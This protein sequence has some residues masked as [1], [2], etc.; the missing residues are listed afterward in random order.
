MKHGVPE[1][2]AN[3]TMR[4]HRDIGDRC[5]L[6]EGENPV[7]KRPLGVTGTDSELTCDILMAEDAGEVASGGDARVRAGTERQEV[8]LVASQVMHLRRE[9]ADTRQEV[10]RCQQANKVVLA[11]M[12]R[13]LARLA[14]APA[15]RTVAADDDNEDGR[16]RLLPVP[17]PR[18]RSLHDLW[19]EWE[20]G[21]P[22]RKPAKDF[23]PNERGKAKNAFSHRKPLWDK[24]NEL[25]RSGMSAQVARDT[26][27][28]V[29]GHRMTV[30]KTLK[31]LA[32]DRR[33]GRWPDRLRIRVIWAHAQSHVSHLFFGGSAS[34]HTFF[35]G[36][37]TGLCHTNQQKPIH[38]CIVFCGT[39]FFRCSVTKR[40]PP[41]RLP[42][43]AERCD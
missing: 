43:C 16:P 35:C 31:R 23:A 21:G 17:M 28:D 20:F 25:T 36:T 33:T 29:H 3:R 13:N 41:P 5:T 30:T 1:E 22:G 10:A 8:R 37:H 27:C 18:P 6:E 26:T 24:A 9:L 39:Q 11:R 12:N 19:K 2:L 38:F 34:S 4:A 40:E 15:R 14:G 7:M 42:L 32:L